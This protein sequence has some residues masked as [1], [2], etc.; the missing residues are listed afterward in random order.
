MFLFCYSLSMVGVQVL[1][2]VLVDSSFRVGVLLGGLRLESGW[3]S[4]VGLGEG[5]IA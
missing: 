1:L 4:Y 3:Y 5:R 2:H